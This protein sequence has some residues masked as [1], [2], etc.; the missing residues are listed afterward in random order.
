MLQEKCMAVAAGSGRQG[1][2]P[3]REAGH[4]NKQLEQ[5]KQGR[6]KYRS[7]QMHNESRGNGYRLRGAARASGGL[8]PAGRHSEVRRQAGLD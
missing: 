1:S 2:R 4:K 3:G 8:E 6:V 5:Q 7:M